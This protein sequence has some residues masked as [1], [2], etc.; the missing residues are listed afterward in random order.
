MTINFEWTESIS[1]GN[2][3]IDSQHKKLLAQI[4]EIINDIVS[5][6]NQV[7]VKEAIGFLDSYIK[8][9]LLFEEEY[10]KS[11]N[12]PHL[13]EHK[14]IH[15]DFIQKYYKFKGEF[16]RG[17]ENEKLML[18]I[19]KYI[20]EWWIEHIGKEDKK[21]YLFAEEQKNKN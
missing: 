5:N 19:E 9:H 15:Q 4:N 11:I 13:E 7:K 1:V 6:V 17:E 14:K 3:A 2:E 10:M 20:G 8:E 18:E 16:N 21:Y 12:Y